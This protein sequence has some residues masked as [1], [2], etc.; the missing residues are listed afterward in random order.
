[1]ILKVGITGGMGSGKSTVSKVFEVLGI[2]I[3]YADDAAKRLMNEDEQLKVQLRKLF[4]DETYIDGALNRKYLS[5]LVFND[6]EKLALLNSIVHPATL[7][8]TGQWMLQQKAPYAIKEAALIFESG[9]HQQLD[10]VIGVYAPATLRIQRVM[11]RDQISREEVKLRMEKQID[12]GIKM[13]LCDYVV[14]NDEQQLVIPQV[15][16]LHEAFMAMRRNTFVP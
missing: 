3:Y 13:R 1:M 9:A 16:K 15:L 5:S 8:D 11:K 14:T 2:P 7:R 12:E 4:G 10:Y 6:A